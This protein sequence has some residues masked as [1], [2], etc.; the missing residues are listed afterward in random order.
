MS[1]SDELRKLDDLHRSGGLT[2]EEF[3]RAKAALLGGRE[4]PTPAAQGADSLSVDPDRDLSP[5]R[6]RTMQIIA[7]ALLMGLSSFFG[8]VLFLVH[9]Q[10]SRGGA[11][12]PDLP[13]VSIMAA[14]M[15]TACAAL[16]FILPAVIGR[17]AL[18]RIA[19]GTWQPPPRQSQADFP[20]AGAKL[21][22]V[23]QTTLIIGLALLEGPGFFGCMAYLIEG[24]PY[25]LAIPGVT[26]ALML[27]KFPTRS[28]VS[29][30]L[31]QQAEALADL[32][33]E[34]GSVRVG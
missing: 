33:R 1:L 17:A 29:S 5:P 12:P 14:A 25:A 27:W 7:A 10:N 9:G 21:V 20:T 11:P 30:W 19:S 13:I 24:M 3:A 4:A 15:L 31:G 18:K 32:R 34:K 6:L 28:R 22:V 8:I 23:R 26:A 2:A 16:A